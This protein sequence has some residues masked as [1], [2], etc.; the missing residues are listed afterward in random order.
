MEIGNARKSNR[1]EMLSLRGQRAA[2]GGCTKQMWKSLCENKEK[3][4][5]LWLDFG[6]QY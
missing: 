4:K 3:A 5:V 2:F 6:N 1:R